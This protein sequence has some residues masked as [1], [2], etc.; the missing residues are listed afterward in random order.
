MSKV[1]K[2]WYFTFMGSSLMYSQLS[3]WWKYLVKVLGERGQEVHVIGQ[4]I[5][6]MCTY[7]L[8]YVQGCFIHT[9]WKLHM[10]KLCHARIL[11]GGKIINMH[12]KIESHRTKWSLLSSQSGKKFWI[13]MPPEIIFSLCQKKHCE[14][15]LNKQICLACLR[16]REAKIFRKQECCKTPSVSANTTN[17]S[18]LHNSWFLVFF[19][20][21]VDLHFIFL[22][23]L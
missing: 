3:T 17:T 1:S 5:N 9:G 22:L 18:C 12:N 21:S 6:R 10:I 15:Q 2:R 16:S 14:V 19:T 23:D 4:L 7:F 20:S 8:F 11:A 13:N